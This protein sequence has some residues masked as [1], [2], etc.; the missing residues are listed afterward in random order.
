VYYLELL[1]KDRPALLT[2]LP[3]YFG[4]PCLVVI[5]RSIDS[6][7]LKTQVHLS[8]TEADLLVSGLG[9]GYLDLA[10]SA[11]SSKQLSSEALLR[12][13]QSDPFAAAAGAYALLQFGELDRLHNWTANLK[14]WFPWFPDSFAIR[15][16]HLALEGKHKEALETILELR[17]AVPQFTLGLSYV[18]N[19]LGLYTRL[20]NMSEMHQADITQAQA[21]LSSLMGVCALADQSQPLLTVSGLRHDATYPEGTDISQYLTPQIQVS[22][23]A[24]LSGPPEERKSMFNPEI[25]Q[26]AGSRFQ[27]IKAT[28]PA[29][30]GALETFGAA[31]LDGQS[32]TKRRADRLNRAAASQNAK[33][34][35]LEADQSLQAQA[36]QSDVIRTLSQE[37]VIGTSDLMD[38]NFLELAIAVSRG[39]GR[40]RV[41]AGYGTGFLVGPGLMM[42]NH[43]V[44]RRADDA[45]NSVLQLDYQDNASGEI[46]ATQSAT[47]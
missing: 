35:V 27:S 24:E 31:T 39:V 8:N 38:I 34:L 41:A 45:L 19:R 14:N 13:K 15:A 42:T 2:S 32:T 21:L 7:E 46:L 44:I 23:R 17:G 37:R 16:E 40:V 11:L 22:G 28:I 3:A 9:Q 5:R 6:G 25:V 33:S 47:P 20:K 18:I 36:S 29:A 4:K 10:S 12:D 26:A 30:S 43:H 1:Q